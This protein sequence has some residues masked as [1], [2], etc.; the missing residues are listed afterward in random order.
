MDE[1]KKLAYIRSKFGADQQELYD[2]LYENGF[3][4]RLKNALA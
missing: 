1:A 2:N 3:L 4:L